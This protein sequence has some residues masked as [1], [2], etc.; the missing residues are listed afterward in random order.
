MSTGSIP[1]I[2]LG[3]LA[4][5]TVSFPLLEHCSLFWRC[6]THGSQWHW[7]KLPRAISMSMDSYKH[8]ISSFL[9]HAEESIADSP[10][11]TQVLNSSNKLLKTL[12]R[13]FCVF[14][15]SWA[16]C[17]K[18][19]ADLQQNRCMN[20]TCYSIKAWVTGKL[21]MRMHIIWAMCCRDIRSALSISE[22]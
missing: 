18:A 15:A 3:L 11:E 9:I 8:C 14:P 19:P 13:C 17:V 2:K 20:H 1:V 5:S 12:N 7:Q 10:Q 16:V 4:S 6:C 21:F 22:M